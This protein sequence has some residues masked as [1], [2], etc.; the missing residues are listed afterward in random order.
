MHINERSKQW[1]SKIRDNPPNCCIYHWNV[2]MHR[3]VYTL[4]LC[5]HDNKSTA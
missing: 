4:R 2:V 3:V 1:C 5:P